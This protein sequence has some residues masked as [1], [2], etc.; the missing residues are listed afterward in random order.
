MSIEQAIDFGL[1]GA[2]AIVTGGGSQ[3]GGLGNGAAAAIM[4]ARAGARVALLDL[5]A[6]NAAAN[7]ERIL[8]EGGEARVYRCDVSD[9]A[10]CAATVEAVE[11]ELGRPAVLVNNVGIA[12]PP[13]TAIDVDLARWD[14]GM[15]VNVRS[16]VQMSRH[17]L[18]GMLD[19]GRGSIVN[20]SSAAGMRGGHP[21]LLY[22]TTKG[23]I[24]QLTRTMAAQHGEAGVR[25]NCV[26]PGMVYTPMVTMRGMSEEMREL[27]RGR[28]LLKTEGTP[29]DVGA[30]V[31]FLAG[32]MGRW[33][34]GV[35]LPV[36][37]GYTAGMNLPTPPRE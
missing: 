31:L 18:P 16:M 9:D 24:I 26:A 32:E 23:A 15:A 11:A 22:A 12:G 7:R 14:E 2:V 20:L 25:V 5:D 19:A 17:V 29:W 34:T 30:A 1:D 27:R 6:E 36:D 3:G 10:D 28:S 21:A 13:G 33:I 8:A 4:L 35:V 37:A